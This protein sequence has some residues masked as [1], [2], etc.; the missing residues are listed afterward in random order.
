M[1]NFKIS[2]CV[3]SSTDTFKIWPHAFIDFK[4]FTQSYHILLAPL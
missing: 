2:A 3:Y 4:L 1:R